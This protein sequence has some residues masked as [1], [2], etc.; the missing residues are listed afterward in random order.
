MLFNLDL[1]EP[2]RL[3]AQSPYCPNED[4]SLLLDWLRVS[5]LLDYWL[6][7]RYHDLAAD[8]LAK[9]EW[10]KQPE[11]VKR[12]YKTPIWLL[13]AKKRLMKWGSYFKKLVRLLNLK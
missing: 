5:G 9:V 10:S 3:V 6:D 4:W 1:L 8:E 7:N 13:K 2:H 12:L 11:S